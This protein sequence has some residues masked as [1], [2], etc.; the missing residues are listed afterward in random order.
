MCKR[1]EQVL[2][3][4]GVR[5][6]YKHTDAQKVRTSRVEVWRQIDESTLIVGDFNTLCQK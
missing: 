2:H 6:T 4:E 3:Q 5:M 1:F